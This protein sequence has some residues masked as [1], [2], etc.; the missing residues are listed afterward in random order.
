MATTVNIHQARSRLSKL[1]EQAE[2]G[3]DVVIARAGKPAVR[4]VKVQ[5]EPLV[6]RLGFLVGQGFHVPDDIKTAFQQEIEEMFYGS[7]K[8]PK[9]VLDKH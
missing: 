1:I 4:L 3:E 8:S 2:R 5:P 6:N 7:P 9:D